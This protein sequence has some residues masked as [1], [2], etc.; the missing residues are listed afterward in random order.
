MVRTTKT[1]TGSYAHTSGGSDNNGVKSDGSDVATSGGGLLF[2]QRYH[3]V[4]LQGVSFGCLGWAYQDMFCKGT[5]RT[6]TYSGRQ[7]SVIWRGHL[8]LL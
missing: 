5:Y 4:L 7:N 6:I 1:N 8:L 3:G 2:I